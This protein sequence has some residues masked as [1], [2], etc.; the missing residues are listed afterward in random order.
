MSTIRSAWRCCS[1]LSARANFVR[2]TTGQVE[3]F[4]YGGRLFRHHVAGARA[5]T[6]RAASLRLLSR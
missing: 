2:G 1:G 5:T 4:R 6:A 3:W